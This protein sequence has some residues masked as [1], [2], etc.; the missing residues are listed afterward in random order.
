MS[1]VALVLSAGDAQAGVFYKSVSNTG[2]IGW[3]AR[4]LNG[5]TQYQIDVRCYSGDAVLHVLRLNGNTWSQ[6]AYSDDDG[7]IPHPSVKFTPPVTGYYYFLIRPYNSTL[8]GTADVYVNAVPGAW[9]NGKITTVPVAFSGLLESRSWNQ[10]NIFRVTGKTPVR[11]DYMLFAFRNNATYIEHDDDRGPNYLPWLETSSTETGG[12]SMILWGRFPGTIGTTAEL[13][14][15]LALP[16]RLTWY[17]DPDMDT[18]SSQL[19]SLIG[20]QG[21]EVDSDGD[22]VPDDM[23]LY[24]NDGFNFAEYGSLTKRDGYVELDYMAGFD[25][26]TNLPTDMAAIF[27]QDSHDGAQMHVIVG[28]QLAH[29]DVITFDTC[30]SGQDCINFYTVKAANFSTSNPE[31]KPYFHYAV[32]GDR[33][34]D[35]TSTTSGQ[36]EQPGN[37][38]IVT[39][40]GWSRTAAEQRGIEMH[41]LGHNL[42]LSHNGNDSLNESKRSVIHE[43]VMNY[44]YT[45][46][47]IPV[48]SRH[49]YSNGPYSIAS[50]LS[51]PKQS[52]ET[53]RNTLM[54]NID[55]MCVVCDTDYDEW[56]AVDFSNGYG[57]W[58][59]GVPRT[60]T[61]THSDEWEKVDSPHWE[62]PVPEEPV[63]HR[64]N[65]VN[66]LRQQ[67]R[68]RGLEEG[69]DF[70]QSGDGL[71]LYSICK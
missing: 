35:Q 60:S 15:D 19:E 53:C 46:S 41:E 40:G 22:G 55:P 67:W 47:G 48:S 17:D 65:R 50:C 38:V 13:T 4:Y 36:A 12:S 21:A 57:S 63:Q 33:L 51:S 49:T 7:G 14:Q 56:S 3:I 42:N 25:P 70:V 26:Y 20:S 52:C 28:N 5:G 16:P 6:V 66:A 59:N 58:S 34:D 64:A 62:G 37:D 27:S 68:A 45:M 29:H 23:E 61:V 43:S 54:C 71:H 30:P 10:Y 39:L 44:R 9:P 18:I 32:S 69:K 24:G 8:S 11:N 2:D 1:A 31:R